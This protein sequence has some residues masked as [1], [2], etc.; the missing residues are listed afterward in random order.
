MAVIYKTEVINEKGTD[1]FVKTDSGLE[2]KTTSMRK[3][4][5]QAADPEQLMGMAW[6]TCLNATMIALLEARKVDK[7]TRVR[8][9]V[10][11]K[12]DKPGS[13]YFELTAYGA[14]EG[15]TLEESLK[16]VHQAHQ[17]CPVSKLIEKNEF[18]FV[19]S[20]AY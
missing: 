8:V 13:Y 12:Q 16:L 7:K 19:K 11:F 6:S 2:L 3:S 5:S 14:V 20:E 10:E 1:G 4:S 17:R 9:E 18:V 15:W